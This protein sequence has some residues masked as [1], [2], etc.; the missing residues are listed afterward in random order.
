[1]EKELDFLPLT[2]ETNRIIKEEAKKLFEI[3]EEDMKNRFFSITTS[4][5][6]VKNFTIFANGDVSLQCIKLGE[7]IR[8]K[9]LGKYN[10]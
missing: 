10:N 3:T 9:Y 5:G 7:K 2:K 4:D 6:T 1:M 8:T